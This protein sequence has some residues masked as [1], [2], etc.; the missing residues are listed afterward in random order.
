M[1]WDLDSHFL[2]EWYSTLSEPSLCVFVAGD[3][4]S[5]RHIK[6]VL[7]CE[8]ALCNRSISA[9]PRC[10]GVQVLPRC[11]QRI[12]CLRTNVRTQIFS[13]TNTFYQ[14]GWGLLRKRCWAIFGLVLL[15]GPRS[16]VPLIPFVYTPSVVHAALIWMERNKMQSPGWRMTLLEAFFIKWEV[17]PHFP[18]HL[19]PACR[20]L[21]SHWS[22]GWLQVMAVLWASLALRFINLSHHPSSLS[23]VSWSL[24]SVCVLWRIKA[25]DI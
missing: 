24:Q 16:F 12:E 23:F 3:E 1:C 7:C 11:E 17:T 5:R 19:F 13:S 14:E 6:A 8:P 20:A 4:D 25:I 22:P 21:V 2:T 18:S 10:L 9:G 15:L